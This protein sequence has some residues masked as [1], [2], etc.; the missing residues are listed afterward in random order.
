MNT[1]CAPAGRNPR[2]KSGT[3]SSTL[4]MT[5]PAL[6]YTAPTRSV[7]AP[8]SGVLTTPVPPGGVGNDVS[9]PESTGPTPGP[10]AV[11]DPET[12]V[13]LTF[14]PSAVWPMAPTSVRPAPFTV[15]R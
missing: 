10:T 2:V 6:L 14:A 7:S 1:S 5:E 12:I 3:D 4:G 11:S 9:P 13:G 15:A 8:P